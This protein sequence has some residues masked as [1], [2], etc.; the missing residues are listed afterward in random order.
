MSLLYI[1]FMSDQPLGH[2]LYCRGTIVAN[3]QSASV[4]FSAAAE[5]CQLF[6]FVSA[7]ELLNSIG[8]NVF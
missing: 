6:M 7:V 5:G 8:P 3:N 4:A 1:L 2:S